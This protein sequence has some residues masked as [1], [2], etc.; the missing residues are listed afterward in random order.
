[1]RVLLVSQR[2]HG[3]GAERCARELFEHLPSV[4]VKT[5]MW[6]GEGARNL[7]QRVRVVRSAAERC[8]YPLALLPM[9]NDWRHAGSRR[10]LDGIRPGD[11]DIVHVHNLHGHWLSI[12][13]V[14]RLCQRVP[15]V[16]TLHDEWA[17]TQGIPYDL[18]RVLSV[19]GARRQAGWVHP[20]VLCYPGVHSR[21]WRTFLATEMPAASRLVSPSEYVRDLA[22]ASGSFLEQRHV[23]LA[24]GL[25]LLTEPA[26]AAD[27]NVARRRFG[28]P[29]HA[30]VVLVA[31]S[32]LWSPFKGVGLGLNAL[33]RTSELLGKNH[34]LAVLL[35]GRGA[36][37][38]AKEVGGFADVATGFAEGPND[39]ALA[40]RAADVVLQPSVA[41][42]F[43]YVVLEAFACERPVVAFRVGGLPEMLGRNERGVLVEPFDTAMMA[44]AIQQLLTD[45]ERRSRLGAAAA[46]WVRQTC[47][48]DQYMRN[49]LAVY[50]AAIRDFPTRSTAGVA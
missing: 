26:V 40:Y 42:N 32:Q 17:A 27:Q 45:E 15:V 48:M 6:V 31:A 36:D 49:L 41:D 12:K 44:R 37:G 29:F 21:R 18:T 11:F 22:L 28:L 23:R 24:Y 14:G 8:L 38:L 2:F 10:C 3:G 20:L 9:I 4:G 46:G 30:P 25:T 34:R 7:P 33:K 5:E 47:S 16:W 35:L 39:L 50:E 19:A 13:A 1:M 43:P